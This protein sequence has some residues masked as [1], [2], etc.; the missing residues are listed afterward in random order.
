MVIM[1]ADVLS[2]VAEIYR[3]GMKVSRKFFREY[4]RQIKVWE[5][6]ILRF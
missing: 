1:A 5:L 6:R 3:L 4:L 2:G